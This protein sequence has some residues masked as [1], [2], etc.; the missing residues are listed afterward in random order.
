M[1]RVLP[2][3]RTDAFVDSTGPHVRCA[4]RGCGR[5][6]FLLRR[7]V[8][9]VPG[10]LRAR[11]GLLREELS[12]VRR[13]LASASSNARMRNLRFGLRALSSVTPGTA[14]S[15]G[16]R[17]RSIGH[18]PRFGRILYVDAARAAAAWTRLASD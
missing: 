7:R 8:R 1:Y 13:L 10:V 14:P 6:R 9:V 3:R 5:P 2:R 17:I 11:D 18:R 15:S 16:R 12:C 4:R